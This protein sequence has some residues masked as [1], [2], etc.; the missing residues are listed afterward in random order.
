MHKR[1]WLAG[2]ASLLGGLSMTAAAKAATLTFN[3]V[4]K[5]IQTYQVKQSGVFDITAWG[6]QGGE[7]GSFS[8]GQGAEIGGDVALSAGQTLTLMVGGAGHGSQFNGAGGG[9]GSFVALGAALSTSTPLLV[10]GG[11]GGAEHIGAGGAGQA[12]T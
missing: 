7:S 12:T 3:Y 2:A 5:T 9:G 4:A 1:I 6:A 11:G 8:G 10:A